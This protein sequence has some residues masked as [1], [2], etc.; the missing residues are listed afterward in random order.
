MCVNMSVNEILKNNFFLFYVY[1]VCMCVCVPL[2]CLVPYEGQKKVL[3]PLGL[4]L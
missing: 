3:D 2:A 1:F 4:E